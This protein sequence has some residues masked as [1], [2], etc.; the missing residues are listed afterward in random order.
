MPNRNDLTEVEISK[1][2]III[3]ICCHLVNEKREAEKKTT[4]TQQPTRA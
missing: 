3:K 2:G 1:F 4:E